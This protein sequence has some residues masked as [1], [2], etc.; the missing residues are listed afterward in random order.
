MVVSYRCFGTTFRS[1]LPRIMQS[2]SWTAWPLRIGRL[3][4]TET[5]VRNYHS[6]LRRVPKERSSNSHCSGSLKSRTFHEPPPQ[7]KSSTIKVWEPL[8]CKQCMRSTAHEV[9]E[10][11]EVSSIS[12][13]MAP[14]VVAWKKSGRDVIRES[15]HYG[16]WHV[17]FFVSYYFLKFL[18][19]QQRCKSIIKYIQHIHDVI[20]IH[21]CNNV[22]IYCRRYMQPHTHRLITREIVTPKGFYSILM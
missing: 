9:F 11:T 19:H 1:C 20:S 18:L 15:P 3:G 22:N 5:S 4:W 2:H 21:P 8:S 10:G 12:G 14:A 17:E 16:Q 6:T 13:Q 7:K